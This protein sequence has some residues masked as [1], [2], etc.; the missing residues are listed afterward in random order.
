MARI[1]AKYIGDR[2]CVTISGHLSGRDLRRVER[3]CGPALEQKTV[4]ITL[5]LT[6]SCTV[7]DSAHAYVQH[8]VQRGAVL[9]VDG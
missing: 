3:V 4:P 8:L 9:V 7:D 1:G 2:C 5:R 6:S